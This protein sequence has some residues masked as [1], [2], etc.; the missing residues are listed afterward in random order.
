MVMEPRQYISALVRVPPDLPLSAMDLAIGVL[1]V[2]GGEGRAQSPGFTAARSLAP[3]EAWG[4][5]FIILGMALFVAM[6]AT[7]RMGF[8]L[9]VVRIFGPSLCVMWACMYTISG[10]TNHAA[11]FIGVPPY[12]YLAYRHS[13]A[14][15]RPA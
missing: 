11:S 12:L 3:I 13:F 7:E 14:P 4:G 9:D 10:L 15:T 1:L 2:V 8:A 6:H 5:A